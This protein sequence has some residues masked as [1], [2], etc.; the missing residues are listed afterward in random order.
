[1]TCVVRL[2]LWPQQHWTCM[3]TY[4]NTFWPQRYTN[5]T[6]SISRFLAIL[7]ESKHLSISVASSSSPSTA[8]SRARAI[9]NSTTCQQVFVRMCNAEYILRAQ[10]CDSVKLSWAPRVKTPSVS[11]QS[12]QFSM[13]TQRLTAP[14]KNKQSQTRITLLPFSTLTYAHMNQR[15]ANA[16]AGTCKYA[17]GEHGSFSVPSEWGVYVYWYPCVPLKALCE[18]N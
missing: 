9:R 1:M 16:D 18:F 11:T 5:R 15:A 10:G 8:F 12:E 17:R 14:S 7:R 13:S 6:V 3:H 2:I 4:Y